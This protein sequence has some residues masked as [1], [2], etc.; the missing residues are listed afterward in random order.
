[1]VG[2]APDDPVFTPG[3]N[4]EYPRLRPDPSRTAP[5]VGS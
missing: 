3:M 5:G 4:P 2:I 1:L